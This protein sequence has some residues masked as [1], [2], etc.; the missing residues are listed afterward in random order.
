MK[1]LKPVEH[2]TLFFFFFGKSHSVEVKKPTSLAS[3]ILTRVF[4]FSDF[5]FFVSI[6]NTFVNSSCKHRGR[7][8]ALLQNTY[9]STIPIDK[10][11]S[12]LDIHTS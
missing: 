9:F 7:E 11:K 2:S 3:G 5:F 8:G 6:I 4:G 10:K 1:D 12:K